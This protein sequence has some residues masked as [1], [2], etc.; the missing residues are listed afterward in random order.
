MPMRPQ[1]EC[2]NARRRCRAIAAK[3][4]LYANAPRL[5]AL[6][7]DYDGIIG[8]R[9]IADKPPPRGAA[10]REMRVVLISKYAGSGSG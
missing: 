6:I 2:A 9:R 8:G 3:A 7:S 10:K 5:L 1:A 4:G